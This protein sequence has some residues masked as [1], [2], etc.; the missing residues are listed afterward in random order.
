[1]KRTPTDGNS[2]N[3]RWLSGVT[4]LLILF[5][6]LLSLGAD[7]TVAGLITDASGQ[8]IPGASILI[9][10]TNT[11]TQTDAIGHFTLKAPDKATLVVSFLGYESQQIPVAGRAV[12]NVQL[13]ESAKVLNDVVVV[14]YGT[15]KRTS[16]T[17][18]IST[19]KTAEIANKPVVNLSNSLVGRVSGL[20][21][22]QGSAEPG[23][24][25]SNIQIRGAGSIGSTAP[26]LIVDGVPRDFSR[27]DPNTVATF[28]VLKDAAAVAPYGVAGANGVILVTTKTG[29]AGKPTLAYNGYYGF[30]NPTRVPKF[31]NSYQ[32]AML[33]NEANA[34]DGQPAAYSAEDIQ[35][36]RDHSDPDGHPDG[37]P[38]D[39]IIKPN[40]PITYHNLSLSGGGSD[41]QYFASVGYQH[42]DGMWSTTYLNKYMANLSLTA[43]V[44]KTTKVSLMAN[45]YVEDQHFP[46][47]G[48]GSILDQAMRQA[49][50]T[51]VYY[52]N[53]LWTGYIGQSLIGEIYHSGYHLSEN[54]SLITQLSID[55]QLPVKGLSIKAVVSYD[56]GPDPIFNN[57]TSFQREYRTPI[58]FWNVDTTKR[59]YEY[60]KGIQGNSKAQFYED[61]SMNKALTYQGMLN[62][63]GH[64]GKSDI[65]ALAVVENRSVK[66]Q[67]F[68]AQRI[69]YNLDIDEL[70]F[71]GPAASDATSSGLSNG[72]RQLGYV[73]RIGYSYDNK[74]LFEA[75]GRY[76]G[77][78]LF[79]PGN[80]FGFF[81]AFSA[82]WRI[83]EEAFMKKITWI[84]QLKLRGS[85]GE[86]GAYPSSGGSI[87][88][89][90]YLSP[91][92]VNGNSAVIGGNTTQGIKEALQGNP[93]ITW[94]RARKTD[95]GFDISLW[96]GL[97]SIEADYFSEKRSNMLVGIGNSLPAEYG[98]GVGLINAGIMQNRGI[99]LSLGSS[100]TFSNGLRLDVTG[101]FT[102]A[103]NKLLKVYE[104]DAT[105]KNV[106]RRQT[107]RPNG[108]QFGLQA[109]GYFQE[110]DFNSDGSLKAG[111]PVPSFG[112]VKA[113]DIRYADLL[114][115]D[116]KPDGRIDAN[117]I[118]RIGYSSTPE[119]I[120]GLEP[121]LSYKGFDVD[122]LFQGS[123]HSSLYVSQYFVWPF[124]SSGS[125][126]ELAYEDHWTPTNT[127]AL[128]PRI[129]GAPT[130]NN[131]QQ[132][133][134]WMRNTSY[135]RLRSAELGYTFSS[136]TLGHSISSLRLYVSGQNLFT[137]TPHIREILDPENNS[138]NMNY[139]QQ[140]VITFGIN[141]T[142]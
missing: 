50:T 103:R 31:V 10:G 6:P 18:A 106:N 58:P 116:G 92:N 84:D 73:Y 49:P 104:N 109:I 13:Q 22:T 76:D 36:F 89:Y 78:Y 30:Q 41:Y 65:T 134:W 93:D 12:I 51:P 42:Q 136:K 121:R 55:Q 96:K 56:N 33:R 100:K 8:P 1:M 20:I 15:Q 35:K 39:D 112:N 117:D 60:V 72:Q 3:K 101:T 131:T 105:Y 32:Y 115:P 37:H 40:R 19:I 130:A 108:T 17:A 70:N 128:Y 57:K 94:E 45:G 97:L 118:T 21:A 111:I 38:L 74:Y 68:R 91:Y 48:A 16:L 126:T 34:N 90:Q 27:L 5:L 52:S 85:W 4:L 125:A 114:G 124:Q 140:R 87:Q 44:T 64:F 132:S 123:G 54:S 77:S 110:N 26:L 82:G 142:F 53:G 23:F 63:I 79:A 43:N 9:K 135:L 46:A 59:P 25:A 80:R 24:D 75:A 120:Y 2:F 11:G 61:F 95:I 88:T 133:S 29:K 122:L 66:Y 98:I 119:I 62:Y 81:P 7:I 14:G 107:G 141:A 137:W 67:T 69:N 138:S 129:T 99:D 113:G 86:S 47:T 102:Y 83:S 28:T 139:F 127:D 71:G